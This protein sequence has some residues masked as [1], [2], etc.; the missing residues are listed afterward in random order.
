MTANKSVKAPSPTT[1]RRMSFAIDASAMLFERSQRSKFKCAASYGWADSSPQGERDWLLTKLVSH[2]WNPEDARSRPGIVELFKQA[3]LLSCAG[4][5]GRRQEAGPA[6]LEIRKHAINSLRESLI[7]RVLPPAALGLRRANLAHKAAAFVHSIAL[8]TNRNIECLEAELSFLVSFTTDLGT[9]AGIPDFRCVSSL[10]LMPSW[11]RQPYEVIEPDLAA[12]VVEPADAFPEAEIEVDEQAVAEGPGLDIMPDC[13]EHIHDSHVATPEPQRPVGQKTGHPG[14]PQPVPLL[15]F[16]IPVAG[17]LHILSN[18]LHDVMDALK[19]WQPYKGQLKKLSALLCHGSRLDL[20]AATCLSQLPNSLALEARKLFDKR[21]PSLH[22]Q[23]WGSVTSFISGTLSRLP[24]LQTYWNTSAL[25]DSR[26][27]EEEANE[28]FD[29]AAIGAIIADP[30][31]EAYSEMLQ[32][33]QSVVTEAS[34]WAEG[35]P[36]HPVEHTPGHSHRARKLAD[37]VRQAELGSQACPLAGRR[38][39]ELAAGMLQAVIAGLSE[40]HISL[41][42]LQRR[43]LLSEIQWCKIASDFEAGKRHLEAVLV[44]KLDH[45]GRLPWMLCGLAHHD[46]SKA[47]EAARACIAQ[48][49]KSAR[50]VRHQHHEL[51]KK[52]LTPGTA[53]REELEAF[54]GDCAQGHEPAELETLSQDFQVEVARLRFIPVVEREIEA[55]HKDLKHALVALTRHGPAR[56][57]MGLRSRQLWAELA[58]AQPPEQEAF[59]QLLDVTRVPSG[60]SAALGFAAHPLLTQRVTRS[61]SDE[62]KALERAT[63]R[64]D[65]AA[66]FLGYDQAYA[67]NAKARKSEKKEAEA[68]ANNNIHRHK[69]N[70]V[71]SWLGAALPEYMRLLSST[72]DERCVFSLPVCPPGKDA[73]LPRIRSLADVLSGLAERESEAGNTGI[74]LEK[75]S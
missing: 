59:L 73:V 6:G 51:T 50:H 20:F 18:A 23:R 41:C 70:L 39:P 48:Y 55:K 8:E 28:E 33:L 21:L 22:E 49:D 16:A 13:A 32:C 67:L 7:V 1:L 12:K 56:A 34:I 46:S 11:T 42:F 40:K 60:A 26:S 31:F 69:Q 68:V 38:A 10:E 19:C 17:L 72:L 37:C 45:W 58:A 27:R 30:F 74:L 24:M 4:S 5:D 75:Q 54:A 3:S 64:C 25:T 66:Q 43:R 14:S 63:Y 52:L 47:K 57:S 53:L 62:L 35:C 65:I 2:R 9:E 29:A 71:D 36:C 15:K 61:R 44:V